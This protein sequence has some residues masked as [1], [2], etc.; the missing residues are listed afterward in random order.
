MIALVSVA[1]VPKANEHARRFFVPWYVPAVEVPYKIV[2]TSGDP[3]VK[4]GERTTLSALIEATKPGAALPSSMTAV[5][6][7]EQ[8]I[9]RAPMIYDIEKGEAYLTRGP[10]ESEVEYQIVGGD[11]QSEW[12]R[13]AVVDPIRVESARIT[14]LPPPYAQPRRTA[15]PARRLGGYDR[16]ATQHDHVRRAFQSGADGRLVG[17]EARERRSWPRCR[18]STC[19]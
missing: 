11:A 4:R 17:M 18:A 3:T 5:I 1:T 19:R 13:I 6:K 16:L 14:I 15:G 2:V 10:L 8:G 9:E 12:H 7:T